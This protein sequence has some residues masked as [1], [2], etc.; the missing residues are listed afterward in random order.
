VI[1][2]DKTRCVNLDD[3]GM[4]AGHAYAARVATLVT[5][6]GYRA[7]VTSDNLGLVTAAPFDVVRDA[8]RQAVREAGVTLPDW[9]AD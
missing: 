8:W 6:G 7:H 2:V 3:M 5:A 4:G 9:H 1:S